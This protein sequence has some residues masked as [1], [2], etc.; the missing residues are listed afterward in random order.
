MHNMPAW[1]IVYTYNR[2]TWLPRCLMHTICDSDAVCLL[3]CDSPDNTLFAQLAYAQMHFFF[4][5]QIFNI[6]FVMEFKLII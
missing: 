2:R 4:P 6:I 5:I 1:Y 3:H